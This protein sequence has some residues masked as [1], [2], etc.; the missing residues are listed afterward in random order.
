MT[1]DER[2]ERRQKLDSQLKQLS[3]LIE[4]Q[5]QHFGEGRGFY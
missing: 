4:S 2:E 3:A 1:E 5:A